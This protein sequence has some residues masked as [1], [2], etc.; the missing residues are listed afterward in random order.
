M[1]LICS[2]LLSASCAAPPATVAVERPVVQVVGHDYALEA[3]DSLPAGPTRFG[4]RSDG[5]VPHEVSIARAKRGVPLDSVLRL[6][7]AGGNI[8]GLYDPGEGLLYTA[9]G[10]TVDA[11]L[12]VTLEAG[13]DYVLICTL[14][15]DGKP[16]SMLGMVRG[17]RVR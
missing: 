17:L 3:P 9:V 13:R 8:D 11:Q 4:F 12:L 2:L 15:K 16:H 7:V 14:E 6:E 10:E 5:T 1:V